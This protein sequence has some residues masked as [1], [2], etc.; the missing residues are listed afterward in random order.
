[1]RVAGFCRHK[2]SVFVRNTRAN[3]LIEPLKRQ[4]RVEGEPRSE[5]LRTE[6]CSD[7]SMSAFRELGVVGH[8]N[9]YLQEGTYVGRRITRSDRC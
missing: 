4:G 2:R 9:Y 8:S 3:V 6:W 1:M 5:T 7:P